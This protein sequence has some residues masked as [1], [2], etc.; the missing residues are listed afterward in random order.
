MELESKETSDRILRQADERRHVVAPYRFPDLT[1]KIKEQQ[2]TIDANRRIG[3]RNEE[4]RN[5]IFMFSLNSRDMLYLIIGL[6][7]GNLYVYGWVDYF[8]NLINI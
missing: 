5:D 7:I 3:I 2:P 6:I 1:H 4:Q 8:I